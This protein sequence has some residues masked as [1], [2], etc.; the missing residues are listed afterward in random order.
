VSAAVVSER[1]FE[2][3]VLETLRV[4][5]WRYTHF[6]PARTQRG[7]RA[8]LSG[9]AGFPDIVAVRDER[10]L[11]IELKAETGRLTPEQAGWLD[12]LG[13]RGAEARCWRPSDCGF[14]EE[15]LR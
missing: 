6:R 5:G 10:T 14:I 11:F 12:A 13:R 3:T 4:F 15:T 9:D 7:W 8:P 2:H 1:D